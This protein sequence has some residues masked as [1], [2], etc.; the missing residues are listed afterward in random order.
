MIEAVPTSMPAS[1]GSPTVADGPPNANGGTRT[2]DGVRPRMGGLVLGA[3]AGTAFH[4]R[5]EVGIAIRRKFRSQ[6]VLPGS[7]SVATSAE[8][9]P[10]QNP[11]KRRSRVFAAVRT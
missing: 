9:A 4:R 2:G 6:R 8:V 1:M 3:D 7:E 10:G 5:R 11:C